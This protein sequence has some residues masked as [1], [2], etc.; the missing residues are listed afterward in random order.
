MPLH[1]SYLTRLLSTIRGVSRR[2]LFWWT[3]CAAMAGISVWNTARILHLLMDP[4]DRWLFKLVLLTL[5]LQIGICW[6][7]IEK[8]RAMT[9][10]PQAQSLHPDAGDTQ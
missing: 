1:H 9:R 10:T 4:L 6:L 2:T 3:L 5:F 8:V 7:L